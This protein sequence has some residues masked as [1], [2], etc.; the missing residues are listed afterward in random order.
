[1]PL[2]PSK[3]VLDGLQPLP[4]LAELTADFLEL[5]PEGPRWRL[6]RADRLRPFRDLGEVPGRRVRGDQQLRHGFLRGA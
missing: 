3:P 5:V 1:M 6:R 4:H 2:K